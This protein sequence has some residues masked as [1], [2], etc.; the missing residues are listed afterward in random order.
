[1]KFFGKDKKNTDV[2]EKS[3]CVVGMT[4]H[5][6]EIKT[7]VDKINTRVFEKSTRVFEMTTRVFEIKTRVDKINT[8]VFEK[9]TRVVGMTTRVVETN[10]CVDKKNTDVLFSL[11][12]LSFYGLLTAILRTARFYA[13][14]VRAF[15]SIEL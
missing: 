12:H 3:T 4:T 7:R 2:E 14:P 15:I 8:R 6:F 11:R 5:V 13:L 1:M 9:S 10:T